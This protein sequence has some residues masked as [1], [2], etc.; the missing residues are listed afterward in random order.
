MPGFVCKFCR[1]SKTGKSQLLTFNL[2]TCYCKRCRQFS[3]R[4]QR[5]WQF[6]I[7]WQRKCGPIKTPLYVDTAILENFAQN[8]EDKKEIKFNQIGQSSHFCECADVDN[9]MYPRCTTG[10]VCV[11]PGLFYDGQCQVNFFSQA[12]Q[13]Y[14]G[15]CQVNDGKEK[16]PRE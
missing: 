11:S 7:K 16:S 5:N 15:Q 1:N 13:K 4:R 10:R 2:E 12:H 9:Q 14:D 8:L 6:P 3:I